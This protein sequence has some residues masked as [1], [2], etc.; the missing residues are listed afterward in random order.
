MHSLYLN[1][2]PEQKRDGPVPVP[3]CATEVVV[4][5][6]VSNPGIIES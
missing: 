4:E 5:D 3:S 6:D 2:L 1:Y